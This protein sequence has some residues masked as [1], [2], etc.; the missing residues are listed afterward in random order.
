[1]VAGLLFSACP[2]PASRLPRARLPRQPPP[3]CP[4]PPATARL[5]QWPALAIRSYEW[6]IEAIDLLAPQRLWVTQVLCHLRW[7]TLGEVSHRVRRLAWSVDPIS[8]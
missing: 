8:T 4:R 6:R 1:M 7:S 5:L 3:A 2:A